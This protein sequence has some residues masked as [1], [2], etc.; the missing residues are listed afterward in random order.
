MPTVAGQV[1]P[2]AMPRVA[3]P[4]AA[5]ATP[6]E[7]EV[8][9]PAI[10]SAPAVAPQSQL[11]TESMPAG[12]ELTAVQDW[13]GAWSSQDVDAYLGFYAAD[14]RPE[15]GA[16]RRT[17]V[18]QRRQRLTRPKFIVVEI[19]NPVVQRLDP[20]RAEVTFEQVYQANHYQDRVTK[21]LAL[22]R[23]S[24]SWKIQREWSR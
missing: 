24:G 19:A 8:D 10:A 11:P 4:E 7:A 21:T 20:D 5:A 15:N 2:A 22:T 12:S 6:A 14:F 17:W 1:E 18:A 3:E 9:K 16:S 23:E 13:A